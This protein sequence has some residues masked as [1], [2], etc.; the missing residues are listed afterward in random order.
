MLRVYNGAGTQFVAAGDLIGA[1]EFYHY[2]GH[3]ERLARERR[4]AR[5]AGDVRSLERTE[6]AIA[7]LD[8]DRAFMRAGAATQVA[9]AG[10]IVAF[11][12]VDIGV[13][14]SSLPRNAWVHCSPMDGEPRLVVN[15]AVAGHTPRSARRAEDRIA[16]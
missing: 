8:R 16:R 2:L 6:Q 10:S 13:L 11:K 15:L 1:E 7:D 9:P 3:R 4:E 14:W 12:H 5:A